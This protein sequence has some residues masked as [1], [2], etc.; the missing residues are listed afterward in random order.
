MISLPSSSFISSPILS[1]LPP[2]FEDL[3]QE[4][5]VGGRG[6]VEII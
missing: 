2:F 5:G 1:F 4:D 6:K 3:F